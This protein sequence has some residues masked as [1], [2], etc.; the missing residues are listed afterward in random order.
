MELHSLDYSSTIRLL[1]QFPAVASPLFPK[2]L[3]QIL[4]ADLVPAGLQGSARVAWTAWF[5]EY[6]LR[7]NLLP[8]RTAAAALES[9]LVRQNKV[10]P[11]FVLR[12]WILEE[13]IAKLDKAEPDLKALDRVLEMASEPFEAYGEEVLGESKLVCEIGEPL[14][15]QR[16]CGMGAASFLGF[17]CSCS[18]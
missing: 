11:R 5:K 13:T 3:D 6:E 16:L 4:P 1:S 10:N 17:Q 15:Q 12:Q 18:S 2:L 14:E 8:E 9:R 7:L